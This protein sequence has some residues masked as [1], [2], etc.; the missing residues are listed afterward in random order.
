LV[1]L[2]IRSGIMEDKTIQNTKLPVDNKQIMIT[3]IPVII[4]IG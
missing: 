4:S 2:N 1:Y 3:I